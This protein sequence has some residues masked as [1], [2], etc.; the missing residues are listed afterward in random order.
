MSKRSIIWIGWVAVMAVA[1][2]LRVE[3]LDSRPIHFDEATGASIFAKRLE[4]SGYRFDPSHYHGPF[5]SVSSIPLAKIYGEATWEELS[6]TMLRTGPVIAGLLTVLTPLLWLSAIGR[7]AALAA[8]ALLACSPLLVYYSRMYIHESWLT[9][10]GMLTA[11]GVFYLIKRPTRNRALAAGAAAGL[12]LATKETVVI[13]LFCWALAGLICWWRLRADGT[14]EETAPKLTDYLVPAFWFVMSMLLLGAAF[15]TNGFRQPEGLVDAFRTYFV[16]E[17]TPGH[18]KAFGFYLHMLVWPKHLLGIWW[19]ESAIAIF[20]VLACLFA[21]LRGKSVAVVSFIAAGVLLHLL[22]YSLIG[23][24][25][26]W[27]MTLP[28]SLACLLAGCVFSSALPKRRN[29]KSLL[30]YTGFGLVLFYQGYQSV[31]ATGRLSNHADNPY[32]YVPT[33]K[34]ITQLPEWLKELERFIEDQ[35]LEPIAVIGRGY[36]P[37]PWYLREFDTVGYWQD[38]PE[39]LRNYPIVIAMPEKAAECNEIL[40]D[41]HTQLPRTLRSNVPIILYLK[42]EIWSAWT[43]TPK[44]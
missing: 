38:P 22:V 11:A 25:T 14:K 3:D 24:K 8:G 20:G 41:S 39:G 6:L 30:L 37:L 27:L 10:F 9:L 28:W 21:A 16:Y 32:A 29:A 42:N 44:Q 2:W 13:S 17:T 43:E 35:P 40:A 1:F 5:Q 15:Y 36:W 33:S 19:T 7:R 34:N 4:G 18:D 31:H 23:Y 12:M 26:P